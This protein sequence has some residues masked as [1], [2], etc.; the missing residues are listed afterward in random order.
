MMALMFVSTSTFTFLST[1]LTM[2]MTKNSQNVSCRKDFVLETIDK[3]CNV[4]ECNDNFK[5][6][7][8]RVIF[9]DEED[10]MDD[11]AFLSTFVKHSNSQFANSP[12]KNWPLLIND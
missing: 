12:K 7:A 9:N 5:D 6:D 1:L 3:I 11:G 8:R 10:F 4:Q 2:S